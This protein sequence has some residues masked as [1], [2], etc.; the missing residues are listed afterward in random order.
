MQ[1]INELFLTDV[2]YSYKNF[3]IRIIKDDLDNFSFE[4]L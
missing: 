3:L 2:E 1:S 4:K